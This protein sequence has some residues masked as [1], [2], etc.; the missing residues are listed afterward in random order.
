M[1]KTHAVHRLQKYDTAAITMCWL[2]TLTGS[3]VNAVLGS[4]L[5]RIWQR[6]SST[7]VFLS[8][9]LCVYWSYWRNRPPC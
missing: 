2:V 3:S 1:Y 7:G 8:C 6:A 5:Q 9:S 4:V